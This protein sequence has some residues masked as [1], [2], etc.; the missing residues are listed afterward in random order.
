LLFELVCFGRALSD[1]I[2]DVQIPVAIIHGNAVGAKPDPMP[3]FAMPFI[4]YLY[5]KTDILPRQAR[6]KCRESTQKRVAFFAG[7]SH[8]PPPAAAAAAAAAICHAL[9]LHICP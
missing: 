7:T 2:P 4:I 6:D 3:L 9:L 8:N 1:R 5:T